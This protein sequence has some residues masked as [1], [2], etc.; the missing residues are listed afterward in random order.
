MAVIKRWGLRLGLAALAAGAA[1]AVSA[2]EVNIYSSRHYQTDERLYSEFEKRTGIQV[3]RLQGGGDALI[4]RLKQEGR[5]SPGDILITVDAGRLWRAEKAGLFQSV[6]S[7]IL[8]KRIPANLRH[9]DGLWFG[10]STRARLIFVDTKRADPEAIDSYADLT[11]ARWRGEVCV[12]SSGNVYNLSLMAAMIAHKGRET[13]EAWAEG[14][15]ANFA[16]KPQGGDI[17]QLRAAAAG[18]CALALA[19]SYYFVRLMQSDDPADQ[20]VVDRLAPVFPDQDGPGTHINVSGAGVLEHAPHPEA[21]LRFLE[22]LASD[23]AQRYFARG[24]N[25]YPAVPGLL[26]ND[27]LI[28]LGDFKADDLNVSVLGRNQPSAQRVFDRAGWP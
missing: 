18:E 12:R 16:R 10:F 15:A 11:D 7:E 13:A 27:A 6:D 21:A 24:N 9:P 17:D 3:N 5:N 2:Q 1:Q 22:Y 20:T 8:R 25:E 19:N 23:F 4:A 26:D 14:V 28:E